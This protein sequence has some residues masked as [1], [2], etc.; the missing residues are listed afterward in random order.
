MEKRYSFPG[1]GMKLENRGIRRISIIFGIRINFV[2][3]NFIT[4]SSVKITVYYHLV[5]RLDDSC[6]IFI[7]TGR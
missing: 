5:G 4:F 3:Q 1:N 2:Y 6:E 7:D